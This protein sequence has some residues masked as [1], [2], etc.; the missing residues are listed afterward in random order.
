MVD[1]EING[2]FSLTYAQTKTMESRWFALQK[3][4]DEA[5]LKIIMGAAPLDSFDTFV[6]MWMK[7]GG[8]QILEEVAQLR[9]Q[10]MD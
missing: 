6:E 8:E 3:L 4:E 10:K 2:V 7:Q 9:E 1:N 5:F